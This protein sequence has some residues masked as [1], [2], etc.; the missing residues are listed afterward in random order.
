M[1]FGLLNMLRIAVLGLMLVWGTAYASESSSPTPVAMTKH[2]VSHAHAA[3]NTLV[4][5]DVG[6]EIT[7]WSIA[8]LAIIAGLF[9]SINFLDKK[10]RRE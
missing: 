5:T 9:V 1:N 7:D 2:Q 10:N 8:I 4:S 3:Q 6:D